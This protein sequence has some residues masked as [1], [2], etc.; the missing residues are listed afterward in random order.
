MHHKSTDNMLF[1]LVNRYIR[2]NDHASVWR[3]PSP[4]VG[5][6]KSI[7]HTIP[8]AGKTPLI[9]NRDRKMNTGRGESDELR[10]ECACV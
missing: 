1:R 9:E 6:A 5:V 2:P 3:A 7:G 10:R 8:L 4:D